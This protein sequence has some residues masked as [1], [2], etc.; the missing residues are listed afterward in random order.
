GGGGRGG[1]KYGG[2]GGGGGGGAILIAA[3]GSIKIDS[4]GSI[5]VSGGSAGGAQGDGAAWSGAGGSGWSGAGGSGGSIRLVASLVDGGGN[6]VIDGGCTNKDNN[7]HY[8][9][10]S[11]NAWRG[12]GG[13]S[14]PYFNAGSYGR[15]RF[16]ADA[17]KFSGSAPN[18]VKGLPGPIFMS[19]APSLRIASVAGVDVPTEPTGTAD[20]N[21]PEAPVGSS[22]VVLSTV[23]VPKGSTV[24]LRV[25]P[26]YGDAAEV[27]GL[28]D[29]TDASGT[30]SLSVSIPTGPSTFTASTTF[31]VKTPLA[32][33]AGLSRLANN[34]TVD[35]VELTVALQG[36]PS[37]RLITASGK[38]IE[39]SYSQLI[40]AGFTV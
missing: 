5:D 21:L 11:T 10:S 1:T 6:L 7:R 32:A 9:V 23:N 17:I 35:Q 13:G 38:R 18:F 4:G 30:A 27:S 20:V 37:A 3:N 19:S 26:A 40:A 12:G 39:V 28:I 34:E 15:I 33:A 16:E 22:T 36:Q 8:C 24:T 14:D 31:T 29:G 25:M 2:S